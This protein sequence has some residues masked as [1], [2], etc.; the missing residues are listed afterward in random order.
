MNIKA[1]LGLPDVLNV[2]K[3]IAVQP[4]PDDNEVNIAGT[5]LELSQR[6]A[7]IVYVTVTDGRA[8]AWGDV[9]NPDEIVAVRKEEKERAGDII[10]VNKHIDLGFPDGGVYSV[11]EVT[12]QLVNVFR[13]ERPDM[14]FSVDPWM[15]YE[16]HPDHVK[17][18]QAVSRAVLF[19]NNTIIYPNV[20]HEPWQ[21]P[22]IAYYATSYPN[23]WMD[24]TPHFE[25]K[26][27]SIIA[28][29]SQFDNETWSFVKLYF[30]QAA[31]EAYK[32]ISQDGTG[33]AE[34]L[35]VL[36]HLELHSIPTTVFS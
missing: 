24:I 4:H 23:T 18:G 6:G 36:A 29:K 5:L 12:S 13:M 35:K 14:V 34:A 25:R 20:N 10:G 28:H 19:S 27:E 17:V 26:I 8:G 2:K 1:L 30:T 32:H 3:V 15:P 11:D 7:E 9:Q 22:Q 31:S 33:F 21:V 16:A